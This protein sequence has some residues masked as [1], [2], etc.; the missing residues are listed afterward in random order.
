MD[1][2][3]KPI[4]SMPSKRLSLE[5]QYIGI[6]TCNIK[7]KQK[8]VDHFIGIITLNRCNF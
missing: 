7:E 8:N 4:K 5:A 6:I 2:S 1:Q 3:I